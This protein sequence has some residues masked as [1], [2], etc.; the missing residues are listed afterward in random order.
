M[1]ALLLAMHVLA[2]CVKQSWV[3]EEV[4]LASSRT[5]GFQARLTFHQRA[6]R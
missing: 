3:E 4:G 6:G 2:V 5:L 1:L